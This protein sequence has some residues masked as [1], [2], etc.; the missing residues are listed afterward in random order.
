MGSFHGKRFSDDMDDEE[1]VLLKRHTARKEKQATRKAQK[2][3]KVRYDIY[4]EDAQE[5]AKKMPVW[6]YIAL[7]VAG[8]CFFVS[9]VAM[10]SYY[11]LTA[12]ATEKSNSVAQPILNTQENLLQQVATEEDLLGAYQALAAQ[13]PDMVGWL[14]VEETPINY[15][16][17]HTP[18]NP[19]YYL[20]RGFDKQYAISGSV[21]MDGR[22]AVDESGTVQVLYGHNMKNDTM[23]S[24]VAKYLDNNFW[25]MHPS[26]S[27]DTLTERRTYEVFAVF[28]VD[29]SVGNEAALLCY[30]FDGTQSQN[31]WDGFLSYIKEYSK[32]YDESRMPAMGDSL[33]TLSTCDNITE[34]GRIAVMAKRVS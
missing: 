27:F 31:E 24:A 3:R 15:P 8:V 4:D 12:S 9:V 21:F 14:R 1:D 23:F 29:A 13:N 16:V 19:E 10:A 30:F 5:R 22:D 32:G 2:T 25:S 20:R 7:V 33:L 34:N 11:I 26:F 6:Y 18:K 17:M 28:H